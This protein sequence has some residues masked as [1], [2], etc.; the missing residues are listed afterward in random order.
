MSADLRMERNIEK[1][2][3]ILEQEEDIIFVFSGVYHSLNGTWVAT[4]KRL[5]FTGEAD[6]IY[7]ILYPQVMQF[8][9][10]RHKMKI[11]FT[12]EHKGMPPGKARAIV[13][14]VHKLRDPE[15]QWR[16][17]DRELIARVGNLFDSIKELIAEAEQIVEEHVE[18]EAPE[19]SYAQASPAVAS[20]PKAKPP[21]ERFCPAC[22]EPNDLNSLRCSN[23]GQHLICDIC[24]SELRMGA[25][26]C[27]ECG[28]E[29]KQ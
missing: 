19:V 4:Q 22:H 14:A 3:S 2:K 29:I 12:C 28:Q 10:K 1:I 25:A 24:G 5:L 7:T 27:T 16:E 17:S 9:R 21:V 20:P 11:I 26:F 8:Y 6:K 15:G 13:L 18:V 23:C